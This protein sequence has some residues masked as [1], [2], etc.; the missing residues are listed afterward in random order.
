MGQVRA[1]SL[2]GSA[3]DVLSEP[4]RLFRPHPLGEPGDEVVAAEGD[5]TVVGR[6]LDV[7]EVPLAH[8]DVDP[9][10]RERLCSELGDRRTVFVHEVVARGD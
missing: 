6:L 8:L 3:E 4:R 2:L 10:T 5:N 9:E 7:S 1:E